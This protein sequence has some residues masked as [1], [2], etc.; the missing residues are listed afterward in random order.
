VTVE[1]AILFGFVIAALVAMAIYLQRAVQGGTKS[2]SDSFGTQFSA[3]NAWSVTTNSTTNEN[4]LRI[5][6]NQNT[7]YHQGL[8]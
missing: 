3:K 5:D 4:Q 7:N 2:N 8:N 1:T 6:S